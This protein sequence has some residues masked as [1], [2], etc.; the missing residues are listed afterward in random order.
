M[1]R[2]ADIFWIS[3]CH[4]S[5]LIIFCFSPF[6]QKI[7]KFAESLKK[8]LYDNYRPSRFTKNNETMVWCPCKIAEILN[9]NGI[10]QKVAK[11][12]KNELW[13][14]IT[15]KTLILNFLFFHP[16]IDEPLAQQKRPGIPSFFALLIF[17]NFSPASPSSFWGFWPPCPPRGGLRTL[18]DFLFE[19]R[20]FM[21]KSVC[22]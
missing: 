3:K 12:M 13:P 14:R 20:R 9:K 6:Y 22:R 19:F 17:R 7:N 2:S 11:K 4:S 8:F 5:E 16:M 1:N 15:K 21:V 10:W 18:S